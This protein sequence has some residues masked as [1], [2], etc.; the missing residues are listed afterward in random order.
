MALKQI[1]I[2]MLKMATTEPHSP[3]K[4]SRNGMYAYLNFL[5]NIQK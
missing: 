3:Y 5:K 2:N 4:Q 1:Y